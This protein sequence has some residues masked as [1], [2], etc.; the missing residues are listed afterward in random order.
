MF[1]K[2]NN[3]FHTYKLTCFLGLKL[4]FTIETRPTKVMSPLLSKPKIT[5]KYEP[6]L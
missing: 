1:C 4:S 5:I 2:K 6:N 3:Q